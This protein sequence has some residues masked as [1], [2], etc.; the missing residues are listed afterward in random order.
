MNTLS[1]AIKAY[2]SNDYELALKLF[3]KSAETYGRKI[4]EFQI[5]KCKEKLST[6]SYVSEDKKNS[7]C[8]SS[9]DIATQLLLS[10]VKKLTLSESEKNSLKNKWKSITGK[11]SENAEIRKV[12]LVPKD[13]PKDLVLAP[14]PDHVNDFTWYKNRKKSLGIKPVNKNIGLSIIIPTFNRSRILDITLA[15]LVN[16]KTNYP[17]EVVV[18]DDGSKENLLTIVQ[19]YEQKLDIKYVR[20]KDY[21]YQL[22]AVRNLGLRTAKYDFVSILDCDMAPQQLWVHSYLTELLEDNDIVLIGPRKYVDTHNITAEQ[23]LNDPYLI[24]SL[25]ETATNNNPSITS[26]GNISLDWRLEHFKKTD[27]L[28]L[29]DSPFRY[30]SCGNVAFSKE[31]LNKVGW[32][33]EEFNHWG[34][35]DVE[36]G[37]RLF[38]KGCFFRV[39]D[40]G[41]AY[42]QEP[43][44]KENETDREA[45]KSITLKIV[46]EKVPY[47][48]RKLL[49]I[50]DS[51]IHRIP[52]V[53]IYIPAY[54]CANY[55]QRCVD[56]ALNQ[57]VVDLE[58][59]ICNDGS[60]D[61]TLEVI[62][63]LYGNNPRVRI[64][65]KP[66]G[67]IASASN[68]AVSFA[69]GYY[70]GQLDSD[71]YLEPD[72][73][74]LCLKEF[75]KDKTLACVYTTNRNVNP[76]GSLIA[77]G[78]N[79][80]EFSREKLT[81]AMIAHHF[82]MF[83]IRAWHLTDGFNEKI[84]NAV[85]YDMFLKLSEVGKFKHLNK[86]C[87]NRVLHGDNT[88]IK[89][90]DTQK[91][92]HFVVVNQSLNR[93]R[94]SNYNYDE[95][96]NLDES[97]KYIFNKTADYQ[98]EIDILKDIKIVQRKD[99]KVAI[100]IFYPNRLDG[101]VKKLN[102]IIEYNK[103]VLII[104]LHIDK[105]HLTSDIK[106]EILE[107]HNKNQINILLN[108][109]VSYYTNNRLIKTKAHLSNMNKL[110]QLNLNLEYIIFDN[111]DSLFIKNDSYNHIKKYDIGMNFSSL[112][113]DWINKI[114]AHSPF[115]NLIKKYFNDND[116]KTINMKGASQGMFIKYTLA[117]DIATIMKEVITLCQ[118]TD[119][120]PEYNTED[121]WFQFVLLILEKKT[122]H[123][124]NKTSTLTYMPWE[125]KLQWTNEQIE[126]AKRGE[127]I[128]VNKFI[129]NS[130]TL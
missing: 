74:E 76:D 129:I 120:V 93:Q 9:L 64:M 82:R 30:F 32:F 47:I 12:E 110:R 13:F 8:D 113:N 106:K 63:K 48:Y 10:N 80:P 102:N 55:I 68:A 115:K 83:T 87:Y 46:K 18:A 71:D 53:S 85:D 23:F 5:I 19:K 16:Q 130:I 28:R 39:I 67:G 51:H 95:F 107:F 61:N 2:N 26:K 54:N 62:N 91:K 56:S 1:Q 92:N 126:S 69:K 44:G 98:E 84:E 36:F 17:F 128:P 4:V 97:R 42:H 117:H 111:H 109:D 22:C 11:K 114:N 116:L 45:G 3:E 43:P 66:N 33:D 29:C 122:G 60:T 86:I 24:E 35:E 127:N 50:E 40:G 96:D 90:L 57:T 105:N 112:T 14:L 125:R 7:V 119:S 79:W 58:V 101:L 121:I 27:N 70:I 100:S 123:V 31:W 108:N 41:M 21:G 52:L 77:N 118:S 103:N 75:L 34:G 25:P 6:N 72:A 81:T 15:C 94:V 49:P 37:Y 104:V 73:V 38:A 124:F 88:S 99:A 65:S 20:Q 59:C 78:Y 89:N